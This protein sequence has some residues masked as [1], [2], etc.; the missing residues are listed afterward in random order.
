VREVVARRA[1][2]AIGASNAKCMVTMARYASGAAISGV[3]RRATGT[4]PDESS[5]ASELTRSIE[6]VPETPIPATRA[7]SRRA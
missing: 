2:Q 6:S 5:N 1:E 7:P 4:P 3:S